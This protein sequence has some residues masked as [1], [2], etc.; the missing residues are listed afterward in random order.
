MRRTRAAGATRRR[1]RR[2]ARV[3]NDLTEGQWD[4]LRDAWGGC[5]YCGVSGVPMQR[6]CLLPVSRGGRYTL[7]NVVPACASCNSS[8]WNSEVTTWIRRKHLDERTFL[9][10]H[11]EILEQQTDAARAGG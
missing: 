9:L 7:A 3:V 8:K 1:A 2:L 10:R 6:D 5:G 11:A 4:S